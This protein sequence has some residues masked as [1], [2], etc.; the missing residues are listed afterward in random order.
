MFSY[1]ET[2]EFSESNFTHLTL[3]LA[4]HAVAMP[5]GTVTGKKRWKPSCVTSQMC[6]IQH[7]T[8]TGKMRSELR[9]HLADCDKK[10]LVRYPIIYGVGPTEIEVSEYVVAVDDALYSFTTILD[11]MDAAFKCF[12]IFKIPFPPTVS[13]F[14]TLINH[15]FYK[16][17][18][19]ELELTPCLSALLKSFD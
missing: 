16:I 1:N 14:W 19:D 8:D 15:L 9:L 7:V 3:A 2:Y 12:I 4:L 10:K 5:A 11:A 17:K 6:F 13:K 18:Y